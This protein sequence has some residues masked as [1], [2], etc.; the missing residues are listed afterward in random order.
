MILNV[1]MSYSSS[2]K[3]DSTEDAQKQGGDQWNE[4]DS[5][6][7]TTSPAAAECELAPRRTKR[8]RHL[9]S[10]NSSTSQCEKKCRSLRHS[11]ECYRGCL[12]TPNVVV[13]GRR[14]RS[15]RMKSYP[16]RLPSSKLLRCCN[17]YVLNAATNKK[18]AAMPV[19]M[20]T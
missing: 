3:D 19:P 17:L 5:W 4:P 7:K 10:A 15:G 14:R 16:P 11:F 18:K 2:R 13:T 6:G 8:E 20:A 12:V 9:K 1:W